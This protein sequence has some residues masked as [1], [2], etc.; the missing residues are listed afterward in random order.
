MPGKELSNGGTCK[1]IT[2]YSFLVIDTP[3]LTWLTF[4]PFRISN[5]CQSGNLRMFILNL[6]G[7]KGRSNKQVCGI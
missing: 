3:L 1:Q 2:L 5:E 6:K 7:C 4:T